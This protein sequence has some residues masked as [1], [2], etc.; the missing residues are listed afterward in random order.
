MGCLLGIRY[1][2]CLHWLASRQ[3]F[4]TSV[5]SEWELCRIHQAHII[6]GWW[7][8]C[9]PKELLSPFIKDE[10]TLVF[11]RRGGDSAMMTLAPSPA[12]EIAPAKRVPEVIAAAK[13]HW[14]RNVWSRLRCICV[15]YRYKRWLSWMFYI[16]GCIYRMNKP[17]HGVC[18]SYLH[19]VELLKVSNDR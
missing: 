17:T 9:H 3:G 13:A 16:S 4:I 11:Q 2:T 5:R 7:L 19:C 10:F 15:A 1:V 6:R 12:S 18:L 14:N 8:V